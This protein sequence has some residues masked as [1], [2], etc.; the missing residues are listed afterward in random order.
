MK[1]E[2]EQLADKC[3]GSWTNHKEYQ[4][5]R[6]AFIL[7]YEQIQSVQQRNDK[8]Y[9]ECGYMAINNICTGCGLPKQKINKMDKPVKPIQPNVSDRKKY[10]IDRVKSSIGDSDFARDYKKYQKDLA[11]YELDIILYEQT[12]FITDIQR[13]S[14]KLCLKKYKI[15][16]T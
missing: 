1:T 7:G 13:S 11:Q 15:I 4:H 5:I 3:L 14:L 8:E 2:I 12:K 16:K 9:C 10:P 6:T